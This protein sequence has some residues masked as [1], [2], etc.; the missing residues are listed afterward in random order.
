LRA[1]RLAARGLITLVPA[2]GLDGDAIVAAIAEAMA[3]PRSGAAIDM[4]GAVRSARLI[5][6][7]VARRRA[8]GAA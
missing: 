6:D 8:L 4:N 1:Q 7:M 5:A 3:R 2:D